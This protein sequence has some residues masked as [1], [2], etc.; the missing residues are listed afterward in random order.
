MPEFLGSK[1]FLGIIP[2]QLLKILAQGQGFRVQTASGTPPDQSPKAIP[3]ESPE[4]KTGG[5]PHQGL[6]LPVTLLTQKAELE[7]GL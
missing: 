5:E 4:I 1:I 3:V 7:I 6:M 2:G